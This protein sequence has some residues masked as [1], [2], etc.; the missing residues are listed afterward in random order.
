MFIHGCNYPWSTD[1]TTVYY[2]LDFGANIWGSHVGV[3]TRRP[4]IERDFKEM[5][6]LGFTVVRW[7]VFCDGRSG[8]VFDE[9]GA[10]IGPDDFLYTD[11]DAALE[12]ARD[13]GVRLALVLLDYRWM[14]D[15]VRE[16][17]ADPVMG[18]LLEET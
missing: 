10:P 15:T 17:V 9:C 4:A 1:G 2:G 8:I 3:S 6:A 11:L 13:V 12:I 16:T 14:F 5:A 7:F 18:T